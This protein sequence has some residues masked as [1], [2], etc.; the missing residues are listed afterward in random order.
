MFLLSPAVVRRFVRRWNAFHIRYLYRQ[1]YV[2][3]LYRTVPHRRPPLPLDNRTHFSDRETLLLPFR[4]INAV[5]LSCFV[6][7]LF[8]CELRLPLPL[9]L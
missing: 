9:I 4:I 1:Y 2:T 8:G 7:H 3:R 5:S 6:L